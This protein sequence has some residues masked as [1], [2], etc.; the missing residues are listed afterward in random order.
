MAARGVTLRM[1]S[2]TKGKKQLSSEEVE[3]SRKL[4]HVRIHVGRVTGRM[5]TFL[6]LQS[7]VQ[8]NQL[9]L[10]DDIVT[11]VGALHNLLPKIA[12]A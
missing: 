11:I 6:F 8:V 9:H 4:A 5:K 1:P 3:S 10:L 2:F 12:T 7:S